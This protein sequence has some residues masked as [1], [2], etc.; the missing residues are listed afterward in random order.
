MPSSS[1]L[2]CVF[3]FMMDFPRQEVHA[4]LPQTLPLCSVA[5]INQAII[6]TEYFDSQLSFLDGTRYMKSET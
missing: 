4:S 3:F 6:V 1:E 2:Y 5:E